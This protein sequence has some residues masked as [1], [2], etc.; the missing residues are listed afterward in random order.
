MYLSRFTLF[1]NRRM[2]WT[3]GTTLFKE[4]LRLIR[5]NRVDRIRGEKIDSSNL[6]EEKMVKS[7]E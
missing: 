3:E 2:A 4:N 6:V 5:S 1:T 7:T